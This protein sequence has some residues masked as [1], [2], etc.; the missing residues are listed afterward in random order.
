VPHLISEPLRTLIESSLCL[1]VS[2]VVSSTIQNAS[3]N[4]RR[5]RQT[6]AGEHVL[7][8]CWRE[9]SQKPTEAQEFVVV[10]LDLIAAQVAINDVAKV[11]ATPDGV[12]MIHREVRHGEL[13][14]TVGAGAGAKGQGD[15]RAHF[16]ERVRKRTASSLGLVTVE[17]AGS[18][19]E[20]RL[21][22]ARACGAT[23]TL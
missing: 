22:R 3:P 4:D 1:L 15:N 19:G 13:A 17:A 8:D 16:G 23:N 12:V 10:A 9:L 5:H 2:S 11:P 18:A 6:G 20:R 21:R 7:A 14:S